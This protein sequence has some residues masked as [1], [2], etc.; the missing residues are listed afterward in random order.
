MKLKFIAPL[1]LCSIIA[2]YTTTQAQAPELIVQ[3][4]HSSIVTAVAFSP[5]GK[6]LASSSVDRT[7]KL[8]DTTTGKQ[9]RTLTG[10]ALLA[11]TLAFSPDG[12]ILASAGG[13]LDFKITLWDVTTGNQLRALAGHSKNIT[14]VAF[15]PDGKR[16]ASASKG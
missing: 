11:N 10:P 9:L 14:S 6:T 3:T 1:A 4:G 15:S 8:W 13:S 5:D 2:L 16:L 7:I 12:K